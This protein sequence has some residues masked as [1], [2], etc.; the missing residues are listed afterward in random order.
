MH[1]RIESVEL[2]CNTPGL[3]SLPLPNWCCRSTL[4]E[5]GVKRR[6]VT[7]GTIHPEPVGVDARSLAADAPSVTVLY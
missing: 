1:K 6:S 7:G 3:L 2:Y 5:D 4:V